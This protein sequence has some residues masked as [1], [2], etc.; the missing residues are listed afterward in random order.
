M[1]DV[2]KNVSIKILIA[3]FS[4]VGKLIA[5]GFWC[6]DKWNTIVT[7]NDNVEFYLLS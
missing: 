3:T 4:I 7:K 5:L 2:Q 6:I 1:K